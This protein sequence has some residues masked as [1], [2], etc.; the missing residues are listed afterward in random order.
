MRSRRQLTDGELLAETASKPKSFGLFYR[1][2]EQLVMRFLNAR[3]RDPELTADLTAET[4]ARALEGAARFDPE[5]TSANTA[6]PWL[7]GIAH[8]TLVGSIRRGVVADN[9]RRRLGG[10]PLALD[11]EALARVEQQAALDVP[12]E[13]LLGNL[14]EK[15]RAAIVARVFEEREYDEIARQ[16]GC[17]EQV[18][19]QRVSRGLARL[20]SILQPGLD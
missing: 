19:R 1:R 16:L 15:A 13:Q 6:I 4:F 11:D 5:R 8:H 20:R 14:P 12:L 9:A 2:H 17:S 18:V 10:A 7:L 3:C